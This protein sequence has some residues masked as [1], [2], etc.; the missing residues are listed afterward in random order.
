MIRKDEILRR[1]TEVENR[2]G[3]VS[4]RVDELGCE[5]KWTPRWAGCLAGATATSTGWYVRWLCVLCGK[6][7]RQP[8]SELTRAQRQALRELGFDMPEEKP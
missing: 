2:L 3:A 4:L 6:S 8:I 5:H 1:L 7:Y